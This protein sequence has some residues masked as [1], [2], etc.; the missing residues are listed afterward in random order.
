VNPITASWPYFYISDFI[1]AF[2]LV[3]PCEIKPKNLQLTFYTV[4]FAW[5]A[6]PNLYIDVHEFFKSSKV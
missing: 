1:E 4:P 6:L 5:S 3:I 2:K